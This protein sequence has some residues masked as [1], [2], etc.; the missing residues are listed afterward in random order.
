MV[1]NKITNISQIVIFKN[2]TKAKYL[3][4]SLTEFILKLKVKRAP[5]MS[6]LLHLE[7]L[8]YSNLKELHILEFLNHFLDE[9]S[10]ENFVKAPFI[11]VHNR[12]AG[13]TKTK[14]EWG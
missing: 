12:L 14:H 7:T 9:S 6:S 10:K 2:R 8:H 1:D 11:G 4:L 5:D 3:A 13:N